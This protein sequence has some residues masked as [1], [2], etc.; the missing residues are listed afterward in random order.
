MR[1]ARAVLVPE[2]NMGQISREVKRVNP[3]K[4]RVETLNRIDGILITPDE[5]LE[6][7]VKL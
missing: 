4:V 1:K 6:R 3:G 5:I 7:L 2:L